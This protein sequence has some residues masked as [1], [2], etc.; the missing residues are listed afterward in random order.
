[1]LSMVISA[2]QV[3]KLE[4]TDPSWPHLFTNSAL[5]SH[6]LLYKLRV[7]PSVI[8]C[9]PHNSLPFSH[10]H[11]HTKF[12]DLSIL[13][14][15]SENEDILHGSLHS[16]GASSGSRTCQSVCCDMQPST[17]ELMCECNHIFHPTI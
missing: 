16:I 12:S 17:A 2:A 7:C 8:H 4:T 6:L 5:L 14:G 13:L 11:T 9:Q 1:M 10:S 15:S 3:F